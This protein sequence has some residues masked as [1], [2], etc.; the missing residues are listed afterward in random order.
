VESATHTS[1]VH[2]VVSVASMRMTVRH[3]RG[4]RVWCRR[5]TFL[6]AVLHW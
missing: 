3:E 4:G 5:R 2:Q 1:S 6:E